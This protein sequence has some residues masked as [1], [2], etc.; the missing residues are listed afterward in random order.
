M[1]DPLSII[2]DNFGIQLL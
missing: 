2:S 1:T